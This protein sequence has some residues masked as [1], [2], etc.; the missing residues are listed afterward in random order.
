LQPTHVTLTL[1]AA[2]AAAYRAKNFK[3]ASGF[4]RRLLDLNPVQKT[5]QQARKVIQLAEQNQNTQAVQ[6]EYDDS[7]PFVICGHSMT[8]ITRGQQ[9]ETCGYCLQPY[10]AEHADKH[11]AICE[12]GKIGKVGTGMINTY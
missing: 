9:K 1:N 11:C 3:N 10:L 4:A 8:P 5:A 2:M 7:V 12:I 6:I